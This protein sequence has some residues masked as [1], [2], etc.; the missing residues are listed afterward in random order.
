MSQLAR[1]TKTVETDGPPAG[2]VPMMSG[3]LVVLLGETGFVAVTEGVFSIRSD[4][5]VIDPLDVSVLEHADVLPTASL[6][7]AQYVVELLT[8]NGTG[9]PAPTKLA[10][11]PDAT[12]D[13]V[14]LAFVKIETVDGDSVVSAVPLRSGLDVVLLGDTGSV[15]RKLGVG[16]DRSDTKVIEPLDAR[17]LE[18]SEMLPAASLERAQYVVEL[19]TASGTEMPA[20]MKLTA[21]PDATGEPV[22]PAFVKIETTDVDGPV[23]AIPAT[24]GLNVVLLGEAGDVVSRLGTDSN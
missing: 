8:T 24:A 12:G 1:N 11:G 5:N 3:L 15:P 23:S 2:A 6:D 22:Q 19:L 10:A 21:D 13:P 9:M 16:S 18:Q 17:V 20:A 4:T 14:Q 7:R